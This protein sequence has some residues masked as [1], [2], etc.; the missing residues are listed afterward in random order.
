MWKKKKAN[1]GKKGASILWVYRGNVEKLGE[2]KTILA[3]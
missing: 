1:L 2:K 3:V